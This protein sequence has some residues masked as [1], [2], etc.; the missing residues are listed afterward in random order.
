LIGYAVE[1]QGVD[2]AFLPPPTSAA[3]SHQDARRG[4]EVVYFQGLD[5]GHL[6]TG[7]TTAVEDGRPWIVEYEVR[8][9]AGWRTRSAR[10]TGRSSTGLRVRSL[11]SDGEGRWLIDGDPAPYLDGCLDVDLESSAMTNALPV[12]RLALDSGATAQAPAAY[13]RALDLNVERLE[14]EY[15]R[16]GDVGQRYDYSAPAFDFTCQLVYDESG[17]VLTYPG[18]AT[19][20]V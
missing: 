15:T 8:V 7:T 5:S 1:V 16:R 10:V 4:F 2:M 20:V 11:E 18:I 12:H 17:L 9:D 6:L 19:R 13:I 3:W 14:Q